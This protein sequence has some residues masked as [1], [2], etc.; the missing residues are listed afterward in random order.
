MSPITITLI[1]GAYFLMLIGISLLTSKNDS[2]EDF[3]R[4][5]KKSPWYVVAFGMVGASLSGVTFISVPGWIGGTEFTYLQ[6]VIG[7]FFGYLIVSFVLLPLYYRLNLTSI[8]EY[9]RDRFGPTSYK[10]GAFFFLYRESPSCCNN[11]CLTL[12]TFLSNSLL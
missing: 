1:I 6:V 4:A 5:G 7:Y 3:F 8:Y 9:L 12:G 11:L 10:T 2:N